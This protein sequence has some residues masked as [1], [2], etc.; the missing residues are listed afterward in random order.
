MKSLK[1]LCI[2]IYVLNYL[3]TA[4]SQ[5]DI[6]CD[7]W[8]CAATSC[9]PV[10]DCSGPNQEIRKIGLCKCCEGCF[11]LLG[12]IFIYMQVYEIYLYCISRCGR[13][14]YNIKIFYKDL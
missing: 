7:P 13:Y 9:T 6:V 3:I 5:E 14:M 8:T 1:T 10:G 2:L 12:N 11:T 4:N